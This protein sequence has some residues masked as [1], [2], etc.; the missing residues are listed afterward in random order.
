[1]KREKPEN[2][3]KRNR[4]F[5]KRMKDKGFKL[6]K[7]WIPQEKVDKIKKIIEDFIKR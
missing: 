3:N 5:Y 2:V 4:E 7:F 1:M 6:I